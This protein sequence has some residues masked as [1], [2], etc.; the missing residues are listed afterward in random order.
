MFIIMSLG[1]PRFSGN[2]LKT[3]FGEVLLSK[4]ALYTREGLNKGESNDEQ[5]MRPFQKL[6]GLFYHSLYVPSSF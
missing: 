6:H 2:G 1:V 3:V 5:R 4:T